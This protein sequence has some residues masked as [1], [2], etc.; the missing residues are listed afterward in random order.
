MDDPH[1]P[2]NGY[3]PD[4]GQQPQDDKEDDWPLG[5]WIP[6]TVFLGALGWYLILKSFLN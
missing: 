4:M 2:F 1:D 6:V 3:R 5:W